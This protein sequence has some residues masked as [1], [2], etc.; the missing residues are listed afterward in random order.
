MCPVLH[1]QFSFLDG[2]IG[3]PRVRREQVP[4]LGLF[5]PNLLHP[6]PKF[7]LLPHAP[8]GKFHVQIDYT[9]K[10]ARK[11]AGELRVNAVLLNEYAQY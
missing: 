10:P 7:S 8:S 3:T 1:L 4:Q 6:S 5:P 2:P 9:F 11:P